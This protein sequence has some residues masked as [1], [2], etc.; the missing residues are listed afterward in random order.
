MIHG[1][2]LR[3]TG[4]RG[5]YL[6]YPVRRNELAAKLENLLDQGVLGLNVTFPHK[7]AAAD[8]CQWLDDEARA[9][10]SV[11]TISYF[12]GVV[13]GYN[14]DVLGF[15]CLME[16]FSLGEPFLVAGCGGAARAVERA[17]TGMG[18][19]CLVFCREPS[20]WEGSSRAQDLDA[21][22]KRLKVS[23]HGTVVNATTL[24]WK[25][26]D[27]FPLEPALL[28]GLTFADLN[29]NFRWQWRNALEEKRVR[30]CDGTVMLVSQAAGSF[31]VWTGQLPDK[32]DVINRI[33]E[34]S[35]VHIDC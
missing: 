19:E 32:E 22:S 4:I 28:E 34:T 30:V 10:G 29:Y 6:E 1:C 25:D 9:T 31:R 27:D 15:R 8:I 23:S 3:S 11:N 24:G 2:F 5:E 21:L 33:R 17:V 26:S 12:D 18:M 7:K 16:H 13:R 14:T 20:E 35:G